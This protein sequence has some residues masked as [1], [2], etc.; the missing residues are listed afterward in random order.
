[1]QP[2]L[3]A[4][5][6]AAGLFHTLNHALFK[7]LLFLGAGAIDQATGTKDLERLGGLIRRMPQT[8]LLFVVGAAAISAL[9]PLNGFASEWLTFQALLGIGVHSDPTD[10]SS[11]GV[12]APLGGAVAAGLLAMTGAL[13]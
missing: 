10:P 12:L 13:A 6:L 7:A 5:A 8:A 3:A 9:P 1:N 4:L 11:I 2:A